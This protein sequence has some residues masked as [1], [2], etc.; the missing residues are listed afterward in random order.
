MKL[1]WF[2]I[3]NM[4]ALGRCLRI[5]TSSS[6]TWFSFED[7]DL[8]IARELHGFPDSWWCWS[9]REFLGLGE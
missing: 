1:R 4:G 2:P 3:G 9:L 5:E 7:W 6:T 8:V